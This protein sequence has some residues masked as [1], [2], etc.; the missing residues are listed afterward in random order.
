[1]AEGVRVRHAR[2]CPLNPCRCRPAYEAWVYS[3][4]DGKKIRK[5]FRTAAEAKGW[6]AD[7]RAALRKGVL[8]APSKTRLRDAAADWLA[9]AKAGAI[10]QRNGRPYKPSTLRGYEAALETRLLPEFGHLRLGEI[11]RLDVQD[12]TESLTADE[13]DGS[14][15]RNIVMPLR[16]IYRR[17]VA[18]GEVALNPTTDLELVAPTRR[19][20]RIA[21]PAEAAALLAALPKGERA[22]WA[23]AFYAGLRRG[24]LLALRWEDVDLGSGRISVERSWDEG[25]KTFVPPKSDAGQR[26]VP[27]ILELRDYLDEQKI[28]TGRSTG[29]V[30]GK[31][32]EEPCVATT[33]WRR[34]RAAWASTAPPLQPIMLHEA[35]HTFAS[36]MIAAG[37]NLKAI[38]SYMGHSSIQITLDLYGHLM[39]GSE[40]EAA[41]LL[42]RYLD[43]AAAITAER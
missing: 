4:R 31:S 33:T 29:L 26:R 40:L 35:R 34:A 14:T 24:E 20:R 42:D 6:R 36:M 30:F 25:S 2:S 1:M 23:T 39:P 19:P 32:S 10:R 3:K 9:G 37:V 5:T 28:T 38:T 17:A 22:L 18:R 11:T 41:A 16:A 12:Y 43:R 27:L 15:I 13:L 8:R 7:A 21:S